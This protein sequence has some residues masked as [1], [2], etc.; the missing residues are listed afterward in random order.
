[1]IGPFK[2]RSSWPSSFAT[3]LIGWVGFGIIVPA[4]L[5]YTHSMVKL[6]ALAAAGA[7]AQVV[8][9]RLAF[10]FLRMERSV[11]A[12]ALW[13]GVSA[14]AIVA[15]GV[16]F[17]EVLKSH[18]GVALATGAYV[19]VPVGAFLS[20]F[21]RDDRR[22]E[23]AARAAGGPVDYGRDAHWLDP[24]VYGAVCYVI[25]FLPRSTNV[26]MVAAAVGMIVGVT[27]AGVSHF[28]L[29]R[30][31]NAPW[32]L[33]VASL[34]GAAFGVPTGLALRTHADA[35]WLPPWASGAT[36]GALTF[37]V[38]AV[39]GRALARREGGG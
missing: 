13:G 34:I 15:V 8:L 9:L 17:I 25:A 6:A 30:W 26:A 4:A 12:G 16:A 22:I 32:T 10:S 7:T 18:P 23:A 3:G 31:Q 35:L 5:G 19:G 14:A 24:F 33:P 27:A 11:L 21:H 36:A 39:V 1:M 2:R 38:T 28:I 20:Y 37:F 29:S